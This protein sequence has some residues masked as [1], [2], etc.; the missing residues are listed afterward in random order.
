[1]ERLNLALIVSSSMFLPAK[2]RGATPAAVARMWMRSTSGEPF[3]THFGSCKLKERY[4]NLPERVKSR[5]RE[6]ERK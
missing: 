5:H 1:M 4:G 3:S 2:E 6:L